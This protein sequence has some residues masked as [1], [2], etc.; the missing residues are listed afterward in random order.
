MKDREAW[1]AAVHGVTK[2]RTQLS[3]QTHTEVRALGPGSPGSQ[4]KVD[5]PPWHPVSPRLSRVAAAH[6]LCTEGRHGTGFPRPTPQWPEL[7]QLQHQEEFTSVG[8]SLTA[9]E[10][11]VQAVK[12][13]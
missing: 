13:R 7:W 10:G 8:P 6:A 2:S 3:D 5:L 4:Q 12:I 11:I 1:R 9:F